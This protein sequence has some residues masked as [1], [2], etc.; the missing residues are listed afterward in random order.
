MCIVGCVR[1]GRHR[2][3][4]GRQR[5]DG[6]AETMTN[7]TAVA[8]AQDSD[9]AAQAAECRL[10]NNVNSAAEA[11]DFSAAVLAEWGLEKLCGDVQLVVSELV[12]NAVVHGSPPGDANGCAVELRL[13][14]GPGGVECTVSDA[15]PQ[16]PRPAAPGEDSESGRGLRLVEFFSRHWGWNRSDRGKV[17][18]AT[19]AAPEPA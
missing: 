1:L 15:S 6:F 4:P 19:F 7:E 14:R 12:T 9:S 3:M 16:A 10:A 2:P 13:A 5:H 11:R 18:W 8:S 17:V